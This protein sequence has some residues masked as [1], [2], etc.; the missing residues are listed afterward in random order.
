MIDFE[1]LDKKY[2]AIYDSDGF[3]RITLELKKSRNF[4]SGLNA[5]N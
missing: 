2:Q 3:G 4:K 1:E 5:F